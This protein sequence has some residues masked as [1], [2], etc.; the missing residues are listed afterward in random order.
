MELIREQNQRTRQEARYQSKIADLLAHADVKIVG[1][2]SFGAEP[3]DMLVHNDALFSRILG[4]GT[5]GLGEAYMDGWWDCERLDELFARVLAAE[6]ATKV[7][8]WSDKAF[9]LLGH[10]RNRQIGKRLRATAADHYNTGN[11]LYQHML[12]KKMIYTCG[13]WRDA[14]NLDQAQEHKLELVA[15][16]LKLK[17]GMR[18]LDIGCG[19]GGAAKYI[20]DK[21]GVDVVGITLSEAQHELA[22][23]HIRDSNATVRLQDFRALNEKFDRVYSLGMFEHVG[24]K[25]FADY[26][27]IVDQCLEPGGLFLLHTIGH[28]VTSFKVDPWMDRYIFPNSILP[29]AEMINRYSAD[30][31]NIEDW[32]N[33]GLD[34]HKTLLAWDSNLQAAWQHLPDYEER[35]KR[36]WHYFLMCSAGSFKA[37]RN[38]LWQVVFSKGIQPQPYEAVRSAI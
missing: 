1:E 11:D 18:V 22:Q 20:A 19:W 32:H 24:F 34:Y 14:E 29:S 2:P 5:L 25:N 7:E 8:T 38:H 17:P 3:W 31:F 26:F 16:K 21:H 33:F 37:Y 23:E 9:F 28:R 27:R 12:D 15:R 13:Y 36:M 10:L 4:Q 6:L 30:Y 35:F